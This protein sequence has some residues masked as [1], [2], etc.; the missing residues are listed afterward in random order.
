MCVHN[1]E[2]VASYSDLSSNQKSTY[3]VALAV[4]EADGK[5]IEVANYGQ[6]PADVP[7]GTLPSTYLVIFRRFY[8]GAPDVSFADGGA[9]QIRP[10]F[11]DLTSYSAGGG[12]LIQ[13][14]GKIVVVGSSTVQGITKVLV[15]RILPSGL[16][17]QSFG[18]GGITTITGRAGSRREEAHGVTIQSNGKLIV[19]G[20]SD[21][22]S[23]GWD[24][25]MLRLTTSGNLDSSFGNSGVVITTV[26]SGPAGPYSSYAQSVAMQDSKIVVA[27]TSGQGAFGPTNFTTL[28][29]LPA[30]QLDTSFASNG[31]ALASATEETSPNFSEQI[32]FKVVVQESDKHILVAG[33]NQ[34]GSFFNNGMRVLIRYTPDG[35]RDS[36][37]GVAGMSVSECGVNTAACSSPTYCRVHDVVQTSD[38]YL[39]AG[40]SQGGLGGG[41]F[42]LCPSYATLSRFSSSG[43]PDTSFGSGGTVATEGPAF[44]GSR[45]YSSMALIRDK[46][47]V[48]GGAF[49]TVQRVFGLTARYNLDGSKD[50]IC[51]GVPP[52]TTTPVTTPPSMAATIAP[53]AGF[54]LLLILIFFLI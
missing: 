25:L 30:G 32:L 46:V 37:F 39:A 26:G 15:A 6:S 21:R 49:Q 27:G 53:T 19:V 5:M 50:L 12:V 8:S 20:R 16:M 33:S 7:A 36:T 38:G 1:G 22:P 10:Q 24:I 9:L 52:A 45:F 34:T 14:D 13:P 47:I 54:S 18:V 44:R 2:A 51:G 28:R 43:F 29:Y 42:Q 31:I 35:A 41:G 48:S 11:G 40:F 3:T 23:F 4:Q 17:D